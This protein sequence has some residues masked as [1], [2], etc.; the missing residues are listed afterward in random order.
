MRILFNSKTI[1]MK[2][3]KLFYLATVVASFAFLAACNDKDEPAPVPTPELSVTVEAGE[4]TATTLSFTV[5]PVGAEACA[6]VC[7]D[8]REKIPAADYIMKTGKLISADKESTVTAENLLPSTSYSIVV[9]VKKDDK[10]AA[11]EVLSMTTLAA[12]EDYIN[13]RYLVQAEYSTSNAAGN[14]NYYL[15]ISTEEPDANGVI[16]T[17]G[18]LMLILD[19]FA[20]LDADPV[21]AVLPEGTY[22]V[23]DSHD[24]GTWATGTTY[25]DIVDETGKL[26]SMPMIFGEVIVSH[27]GAEYLIRAD[28][29]PVGVED[30][31]S[32]MYRGPIT[33]VQTTSSTYE[34]FDQAQN[35]DFELSTGRFWANWFSPLCCDGSIQLFTGKFDNTGVQT[36]GYYINIPIYTPLVADLTPNPMPIP[37]GVYNITNVSMP[38]IY[39]IPYTITMGGYVDLWGQLYPGGCYVSYLSD[40]P[41]KK[42]RLG[43][44]TEGTVTVKGT[45]AAAEMILDLKTDNGVAI[46]GGYKGNLNVRNL[47]DNSNMPARPWSDIDSNIELSFASNIYVYGYFMENFLN[48]THNTWVVYMVPNAPRTGSAMY[49]EFLS[50]V[51]A[52]RDMTGTYNVSLDMNNDYILFPGMTDLGGS[53][54]DWSWYIDA[55]KI[56]GDGNITVAAPV[57][58]G[59][60]TITKEGDGYKFVF[61]LVDDAGH[62]IKGEW[63]GVVDLEDYDPNVP[64]KALRRLAR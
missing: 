28:L 8:A 63:T 58:G 24:V 35:I 18:N 54:V 37:E 49:L 40:T 39:Q 61:D 13:A 15:V 23:S 34:P 57:N 14:G 62:T 59:T 48:E 20:A 51:S 32:V 21:N 42:N 2:L 5:A 41:S 6:Y 64:A 11:S 17:P 30:A 31:I 50:P 10:V 16:S 1:D 55:S 25:V 19:L 53:S 56:T 29:T 7:L 9:A 52:G 26:S 46:T 60:M 12:E 22:K 44:I 4:A 36:E 27:E 47:V 38:N 33:F 43:F 45:G 3:R